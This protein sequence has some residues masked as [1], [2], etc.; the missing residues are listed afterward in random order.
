VDDGCSGL[1]Q[2]ISG[3]NAEFRRP[4]E[5]GMSP[6]TCC[7]NPA[8][9]DSCRQTENAPTLPGVLSG[10]APPQ[11]SCPLDVQP[12]SSPGSAAAAHGHG[13]PARS[14]REQPRRSFKASARPGHSTACHR[15]G[16]ASPPA[17]LWEHPAHG[18][19]PPC[20][21]LR[22]TPTGL[23][24]STRRT[25]GKRARRTMAVSRRQG[26]R[27]TAQWMRTALHPP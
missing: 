7:P 24:S 22:Q 6:D 3:T 4:G 5:K 26:R 14:P 17:P 11:T 25:E 10:V 27:R 20:R 18:G 23:C 12:A 16:R 1:A 15:S 13:V 9:L 8:S 21:P 2:R 19:K